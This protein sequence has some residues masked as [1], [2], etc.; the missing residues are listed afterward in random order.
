MEQGKIIQKTLNMPNRYLL[1]ISK[2]QKD[3]SESCDVVVYQR[4]ISKG[5]TSFNYHERV[6]NYVEKIGEFK[7]ANTKDGDRFFSNLKTE[8]IRC[9]NSRLE[10]LARGGM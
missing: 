8:M 10:N 5:I 4:K 6:I 9:I 3:S 7:V 1:S 2:S